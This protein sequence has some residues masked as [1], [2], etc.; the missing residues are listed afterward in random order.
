MFKVFFEIPVASC[1]DQVYSL[2]CSPIDATL[3]ATGGGVMPEEFYGRLAK[4]IG[5]LSF[6]VFS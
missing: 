2:A 5:L 6:K 4:E 3:V 1:V